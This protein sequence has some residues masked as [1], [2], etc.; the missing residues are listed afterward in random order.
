MEDT[1]SSN[2]NYFRITRVETVTGS[3]GYDWLTL[4]DVGGSVTITDS[5]ET[6][7]GGAGIDRITLGSG[8]DQLIT[9]GV[10]FFDGGAGSDHI[11]LGTR[12]VTATFQNVE[13]IVGLSGIDKVTVIAGAASI[14]G[15][16][17]NDIL[18]GSSANDT[19][20]GGADID[21][22]TGGGGEDA[23]LGTAAELSGDTIT[24]FSTGDVIT[25]NDGVVGAITATLVGNSLVIDADGS[26]GPAAAFTLNLSTV[27]V[28]R[29]VISEKT[30]SFLADQVPPS[31]KISTSAPL[32]AGTPG[33]VT[34]RF[35]EAVRN[36]S[37]SDVSVTNG[38]L[39]NLVQVDLVTYSATFTPGAFGAATIKVAAGSYE[40]LSQ[41]PGGE[42]SLTVQVADQTAPTVSIIAPAT[43]A[44]GV[45]TTV[46]FSFSEEVQGFALD[47]VVAAN[48]TLSN[49]VRIDAKTY[50]A[51]F[52][53]ASAGIGSLVIATGSY[54]DAA[55]N[56]GLGAW[57][58]M[59]VSEAGLNKV[60]TDAV[61]Q[62]Y[63]SVLN[64]ALSGLAGNDVLDGGWGNDRIW[65]G[66]GNDK[67]Y[68]SL[69]NDML[70]G[71]SGSDALKGGD[72]NDT[73][74]G[75]EGNDNLTGGEGADIF[76]FDT[77]PSKGGNRD[78][79]IDFDPAE[80]TIWLDNAVFT[81]LTKIGTLKKA[82]FVI[83]NKAKDKND[84]IVY[85]KNK[86]V[87]SYDQD[88]SGSK[89]AVEIATLSKNL[90]LTYKDF[91]II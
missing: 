51:T 15:G 73:L 55:G 50:T 86:G 33:T 71:E 63:G 16:G 77:K 38:T 46:T 53:P 89:K 36:F 11:T 8:D 23:F 31:L 88:G 62:L 68:G 80:D 74:W 14:S 79:I 91:F 20:N 65:G 12:G 44:M 60:G 13:T 45:P 61:D 29:L 90:K 22:L 43:G 37:L 58:T 57:R 32:V 2:T 85:D 24:D 17:G 56:A 76:V 54:R 47:D 66:F 40:D 9:V 84:F 10:E 48:G 7:Y 19:I 5:V 87:L 72:D 49:L 41:D 70:M 30:I 64:D 28:G 34:F 75:G 27:P 82:N 35:S 6:V 21:L 59:A 69:G 1:I 42:T 81:K 83:G 39:T 78:K 52:A 4:S 26:A 18:I 67:L 25:V 3:S